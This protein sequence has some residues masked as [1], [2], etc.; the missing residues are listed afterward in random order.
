[1]ATL[2]T[3]H[4]TKVYKSFK[5]P[6]KALV[7]GVFLAPVAELVWKH[8]PMGLQGWCFISAGSASQK[9]HVRRKHREEHFL[10]PGS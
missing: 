3:R 9:W 7:L 6:R 8:L 10:G 4:G 1:M 5:E 2:A